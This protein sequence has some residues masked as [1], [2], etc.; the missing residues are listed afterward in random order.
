[1]TVFMDKTLDI[2]S[3][4]RAQRLYNKN[5]E[6]E[7]KCKR[8][9]HARVPSDP[10][11][12]QQM[13][14]NY[15]AII[16]ED[17]DF[18]EQHEI[19]YALWQLHY[20]R[21]EELRA[22]FSAALS[23]TGSNTAQNGK[24]P[25][26][27]DRITKIRSQFKAFL[28]EATGFY[29]DLMLKIR[30]KYGIPLGNFSDDQEIPNFMSK[31]GNKSV[32]MKKGLISCHRCLIYLGD[33]ARYKG[34]YG[35]GESKVRDFSAASSYYTQASSLWPSS[36]NP[37]HQLAILASYSGDELVAIYRYFRS[38]STDNPFSTARDNL[39]I[40]F[41]KNRQ[42]Y[43]QLLCEV[44]APPV[45]SQPARVSGKGRSKGEAKVFLK[46]NKT[47]ATSIKE[48][49]PNTPETFKAF[50]VRFVRLNGILFTRT[51]L[52]TFGEVLLLARNDLVELLSSG[53]EDQFKF[54]SNATENGLLIVRLVATL[55]FSVHNVNRETENKSYAE[56]VQ[57]S[58]VLQNAFTALFQFMGH[59]INRCKQL[60]DPSGSCLLSG[61]LVFVEWL[62]CHPDISF[63]SELEEKQVSA[64][65]FFWN[66]CV[67]LLNTLLESGF[68]SITE[69]EDETCFSNMSTYE[70]GE[71]ANCLALWEDFELRGFLPLHP[72]Q[73]V[74]D[75]SKKLPFGSDGNVKEKSFRI[76]RIIM[77][78][79]AIANIVQAG[80]EGIYIDRS[81][82][83][84]CFGVEPHTSDVALSSSLEVPALVEMR[85]EHPVENFPQVPSLASEED[86]HEEEDE[87]EIVFQP[88][89]IDKQIDGVSQKLALKV[90]GIGHN[91]S[92]GNLRS[93][94][95]S[96]SALEDGH[97]VNKALDMTSGPLASVAHAFP[98][99]MQPFQSNAGVPPWLTEQRDSIGTE[100]N[101]L[102]I[103]ENGMAMRPE[104][105]ES[106]VLEC[107]HASFLPQ[108]ANLSVAG[109][110]S[111]HVPET[112]IPSKYD[113]I[114][115][116][117]GTYDNISVNSSTS[118]LANAKRSPVSRP[119]RHFGPPPGFS[120]HASK[121]IDESLPVVSS[122]NKNP[123]MDDYSWLDGYQFP[124]STRGFIGFN[125]F[126]NHPAKAYHQESKTNSLTGTLGF[127]FPG[128]QVPTPEAQIGL[129]NGQDNQFA[130]HLKLLQEQQQYQNRNEQ[131][132]PFM[133]QYKRSQWEG[134]FF[135]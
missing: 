105:H 106:G 109:A 39:I 52:E 7:N 6:L 65:S 93:Y 60:R 126:N 4:E 95:D 1:M 29:H 15:E 27:P 76:K 32:E 72:A 102:R 124:A 51:S 81:I 131:L 31:E 25:S 40:A 44:K 118:M 123:L 79:K 133:E 17:H 14:E 26:L 127:P 9:A 46:D 135:V 64:R 85:Q 20:R 87:E 121:Q 30:A 125:N 74:L 42:S 13:R 58:V 50:S 37:H 66:H 80:Q 57:R 36:G 55:I 101:N 120:T 98:Q 48:R 67:S 47:E 83:K 61:V 62:A 122:G 21:I 63:G 96:F 68:I 59:I 97:L 70:E 69:D 41:E 23:S 86:E 128:K 22:H 2:S 132:T 28:S 19:E 73:V 107:T 94:I 99:Q 91:A 43:S 89:K 111:A 56:I 54:G 100:L 49:L 71:T 113:S 53:P 34:L 75:F 130:A 129:Q 117:E 16:L 119:V 115:S 114:M 78:G 38:L 10:T 90:S 3:R 84:F 8:S 35:D 134:R 33:L 104:L 11:A 108:S 45:K 103:I 92:N 112:V 88:L 116:L 110:P 5:V 24:S 18:S 77:A 12:W 82:K